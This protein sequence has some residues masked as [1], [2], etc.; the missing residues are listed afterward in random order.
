MGDVDTVRALAQG[1]SVPIATRLGSMVIRLPFT[2]AAAA[3]VGGEAGEPMPPGV[4]GEGGEPLPPGAGG[5]VGGEGGE[6]LPPGHGVPPGGESGEPQLPSAPKKGGFSPQKFGLGLLATIVG[7]ELLRRGAKAM[8]AA[9]HR[10]WIFDPEHVVEPLVEGDLNE[11]PFLTGDTKIPTKKGV[12]IPLREALKKGMEDLKD[13]NKEL[14]D[15]YKGILKQQG[16][17]LEK[18]HLDILERALEKKRNSMTDREWEE[19]KKKIYVEI[20][21]GDIHVY[22]PEPL[23]L[24]KKAS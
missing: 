18:V 12:L 6:Q 19:F 5:G 17:A 24:P 2:R 16:G 15:Y 3:P 4:G 10:L 23:K 20:K 9:G 14:A 22:F 21:D 7:E 13:E 11:K 1:I 8:D